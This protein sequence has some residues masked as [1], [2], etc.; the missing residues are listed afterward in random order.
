MDLYT[1][2]I[3]VK[4]SV[5]I[6]VLSAAIILLYAPN[7]NAGLIM[8]APKYTGLNSGLVGYWSFNGPD[9]AGLSAYDRSGSYATG[10]LVNGPKR[11]AGKIG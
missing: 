6:S 5:A 9:M 10:T 3:S 1:I 8:N 4:I 11:V 2:K 7:A